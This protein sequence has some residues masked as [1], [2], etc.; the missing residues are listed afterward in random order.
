[1]FA[2]GVA[3]NRVST[4]AA[5][6]LDVVLLIVS[7]VGEFEF[8]GCNRILANGDALCLTLSASYCSV[9]WE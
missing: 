2:D 8:G 1:M 9:L 4:C 5:E 6:N 7:Q 3:R